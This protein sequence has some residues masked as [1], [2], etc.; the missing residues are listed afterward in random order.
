MIGLQMC[1]MTKSTLKMAR[2]GGLGY[3][4]AR[5]GAHQVWQAG[6]VE[7]IGLALRQLLNFL[8]SGVAQWRSC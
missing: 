1:M 8:V 2:N 5:V 4:W 3:E 7:A 6:S